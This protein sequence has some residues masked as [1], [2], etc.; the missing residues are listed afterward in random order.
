M[1]FS[2]TASFVASGLLFPAGLYTTTKAIRYDPRYLLLAL[3]PIIFSVQQCIE[4]M[5]W[6]A[7]NEQNVTLLYYAS[8]IYLWVAFLIWPAYFPL[9]IYLIES[10]PIRRQLFI[11]L[12]ILGVAL[13]LVTYGP[14]LL[15]SN[16]F[17]IT[18]KYQSINYGIYRTTEANLFHTIC[19]VIILV[20]SSAICSV[21]KIKIFCG[22][23]ILSFVISILLFSYA[24]VSVWCFF[25]AFLSLY[26][27]YVMRTHQ[28][29]T[30]KG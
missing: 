8:L 9:S 27:I 15:K 18:L 4:G 30:V 1:C 12:T 6:I 22:L 2:A 13:G 3:M 5:A 24:L 17:D 20:A 25:A 21:K 14:L 23:L 16:F 7:I 19:Y 10:H 26:L 11:A 28:M 29:F